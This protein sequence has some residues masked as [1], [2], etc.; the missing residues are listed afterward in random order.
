MVSVTGVGPVLGVYRSSSDV[1][2]CDGHMCGGIA[3]AVFLVRCNYVVGWYVASQL[4]RVLG[5]ASAA[6][7]CRQK[8]R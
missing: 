2:S 6:A 3:T 1:P 5:Q 4:S 8:C 7:A